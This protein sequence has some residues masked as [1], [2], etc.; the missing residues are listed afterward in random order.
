VQSPGARPACP[1]LAGNRYLHVGSPP[2]RRNL[3]ATDGPCITVA[4]VTAKSC[5]HVSIITVASQVKHRRLQTAA[6]VEQIDTLTLQA[7]ADLQ[8]AG[9]RLPFSLAASASSCCCVGAKA[10][11]TSQGG[12]STV[13]TCSP[14][15]EQA[16]P[17]SVNW[18]ALLDGAVQVQNQLTLAA[19]SRSRR[20]LLKQNCLGGAHVQL[21]P[22]L[23]LH[24][25]RYPLS[26][27][28]YPQAQIALCR[29]ATAGSHVSEQCANMPQRPRQRQCGLSA[30]ALSETDQV[31]PCPLVGCRCT[32]TCRWQLPGWAYVYIDTACT[33]ALSQVQTLASPHLP[34]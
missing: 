27:P 25:A 29:E 28:H 11:A 31:D 18:L 6:A 1:P 9:A 19:R 15:T 14:L 16:S 10:R 13:D 8:G 2:V 5:Q 12:L 26:C 7:Q 33:T 30:R 17:H 3:A 4:H 34:Y 21:G 23:H 22:A 24:A 32:A 20:T